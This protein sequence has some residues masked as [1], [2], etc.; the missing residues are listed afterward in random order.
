MAGAPLEAFFQVVG[1]YAPIMKEILWKMPVSLKPP[2]D[3]V[4]TWSYDATTQ[5][6][7]PPDKDKPISEAE[8]RKRLLNR[9]TPGRAALI[10]FG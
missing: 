5:E 8:A 6:L 2:D 10:L 9:K 1:H 3:E 7:Y 4:G